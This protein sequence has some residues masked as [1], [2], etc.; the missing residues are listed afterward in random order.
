MS[1][2]RLHRVWRGHVPWYVRARQAVIRRERLDE[3]DRDQADDRC[4]Y[5]EYVPLKCERARGGRNLGGTVL[6]DVM[7]INRFPSILQVFLSV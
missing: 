2:A 1:T 7:N 4:T 3:G 5:V 6:F